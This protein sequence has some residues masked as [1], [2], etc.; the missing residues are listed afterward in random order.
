MGGEGS[1]SC[2]LSEHHGGRTP[3][4]QLPTTAGLPYRA[5]ED[6]AAMPTRATEHQFGGFL[7]PSGLGFTETVAG[8]GLHADPRLDPA[9]AV[10]AQDLTA[11]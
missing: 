8:V 2:D 5:V 9:P 6:A 4:Q 7:R 10:A 3:G 1:E 11:T